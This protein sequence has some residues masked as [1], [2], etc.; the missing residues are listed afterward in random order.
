MGFRC[1]NCKQDFGLDKSKLD[2]H[3]QNSAEC[4][5]EVNYLLMKTEFGANMHVEKKKRIIVHST[6]GMY[7]A[8]DIQ[9]NNVKRPYEFIGDHRWRKINVV[10]KD[11]KS[12]R[13]N[14]SH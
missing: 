1:P 5:S 8:L 11:R 2:E 9:K 13:L 4:G 10:S 14:S 3:F 7:K 12:T 6:P